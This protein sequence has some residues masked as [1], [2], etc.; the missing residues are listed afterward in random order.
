VGFGE[1]RE[2]FGESLVLLGDYAALND[3]QDSSRRLR[4]TEVRSAF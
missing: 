2:C 3:G 1:E 4:M